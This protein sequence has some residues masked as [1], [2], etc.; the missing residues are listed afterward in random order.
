M[1]KKSYPENNQIMLFQHYRNYWVLLL[2]NTFVYPSKKN[3]QRIFEWKT[4]TTYCLNCVGNL[5]RNT[6]KKTHDM[7]AEIQRSKV[8]I[9]GKGAIT[10]SRS[11]Q[12]GSWAVRYTKQTHWGRQST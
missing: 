9:G 6:L 5:F 4:F 3:A 1:V 12:R 2:L 8:E 10:D 7:S 11:G